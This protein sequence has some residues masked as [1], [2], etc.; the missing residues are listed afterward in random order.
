MASVGANQVHE[1]DQRVCSVLG[2]EIDCI[3]ALLYGEKRIPKSVLW[4]FRQTNVKGFYGHTVMYYGGGG[5][6]GGRGNMIARVTGVQSLR[7]WREPC[8]ASHRG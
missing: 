7:G 2:E 1:L 4:S 5:H 3:V 8:V 6:F